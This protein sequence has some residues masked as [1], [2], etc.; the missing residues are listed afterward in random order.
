MSSEA[1]NKGRPEVIAPFD[2]AP[3]WPQG[4]I[5]PIWEG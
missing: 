3:A 1:D 2:S 5:V 4:V